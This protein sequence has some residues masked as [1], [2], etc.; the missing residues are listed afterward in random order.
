M[1]PRFWESTTTSKYYLDDNK[2]DAGT[3][4][5]ELIR[6]DTGINVEKNCKVNSPPLWPKGLTSLGSANVKAYVLNHAGARPNDRDAVDSRLVDDAINDTGTIKDCVSGCARSA[7][8]YPILAENIQTLSL[9]NNPHGDF[10]ADGYTNLEEW[11]HELA[12]NLEKKDKDIPAPT[13]LTI[14][15]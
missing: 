2:T 14:A 11:L 10:D 15:K 1:A 3:G 4:N 7:G 5:W 13:D 12:S 6:D 9:P 8:G